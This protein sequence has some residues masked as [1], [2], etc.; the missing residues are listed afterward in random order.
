[1]MN[2]IKEI[3]YLFSSSICAKI[4]LVS[5]F[6]HENIINSMTNFCCLP[7]A[8]GFSLDFEFRVVFQDWFLTKARKQSLCCCLDFSTNK[9][10]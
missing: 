3:F 2:K 9:F 1:M 5:M 4:M 8:R 6:L 10:F 7:N